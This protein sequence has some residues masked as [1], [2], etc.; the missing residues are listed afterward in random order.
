MATQ[1][2]IYRALEYMLCHKIGK[3]LSL[4]QH[5]L[6]TITDNFSK[7]NLIGHGGY[8]VVYK[9]CGTFFHFSV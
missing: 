5:H 9:V 3:P 6:E 2:D 1:D 8:G 4:K 7:D